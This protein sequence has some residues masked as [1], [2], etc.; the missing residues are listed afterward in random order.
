M[1]KLMYL[2]LESY[3]W[4]SLLAAVLLIQVDKALSSGYGFVYAETFVSEVQS[5]V[6]VIIMSG[7]KIRS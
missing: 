2:H 7:Y 1:R 3:Y 5:M 6:I 4:R